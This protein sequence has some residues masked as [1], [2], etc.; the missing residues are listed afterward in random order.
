MCKTS[1]LFLFLFGRRAQRR[2]FGLIAS[3]LMF[4]IFSFFFLFGRRA[5]RRPFG[6]I[7]IILIVSIFSFSF[8]LYLFFIFAHTMNTHIQFK[9]P[10]SLFKKLSSVSKRNPRYSSC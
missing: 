7:A 4:S 6:F 3:T 1:F 9:I 5:Q 8:F 2:P 10:I